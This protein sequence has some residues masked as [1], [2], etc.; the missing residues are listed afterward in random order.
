MLLYM[1]FTTSSTVEVYASR[2]RL[3]AIICSSSFNIYLKLCVTLMY[4]VSEDVK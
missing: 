4:L 3:A 1:Y 2:G